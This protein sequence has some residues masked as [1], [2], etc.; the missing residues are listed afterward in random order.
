MYIH[1][2]PDWPNFTWDHEKIYALLAPLR[3]QQLPSRECPGR[4]N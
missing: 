1:E 4:R 2:L 3:H